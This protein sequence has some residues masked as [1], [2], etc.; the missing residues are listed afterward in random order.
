MKSNYVLSDNKLSIIINNRVCYSIDPDFYNVDSNLLGNIYLLHTLPNAKF[1]ETSLESMLYHTILDEQKKKLPIEEIRIF[2]TNHMEF[3]RSFKERKRIKK[4]LKLNNLARLRN[5]LEDLNNKLAKCP[6][7][8]IRVCKKIGAQKTKSI[9]YF[10]YL[11][12]EIIKNAN[13]ECL[14]IA[15]RFPA[16]YR[17]A[18]YI[19]SLRD[20]KFAQLAEVFPL[21]ACQ[22]LE[23][24]YRKQR[25]IKAIFNSDDDYLNNVIEKTDLSM[26]LKDLAEL[27]KLPMCLRNIKPYCVEYAYRYEAVKFAEKYPQ[28]FHAFMPTK[29]MQQHRWLSVLG[30]LRTHPFEVNSAD[31]YILWV[32]KNI[33]KKCNMKLNELNLYISEI[34]DWRRATRQNQDVIRLRVENLSFNSKLTLDGAIER[35]KQWHEQIHTIQREQRIINANKYV[36]PKP[37]FNDFEKDG[38]TISALTKG[39]DLVYEGDAMHHCVNTYAQ[40][41]ADGLCYI[42]SLKKDGERKATIELSI[43]HSNVFSYLQ[44]TMGIT[45]ITGQNTYANTYTSSATAPLMNTITKTYSIGQIRAHCNGDP[46]NEAKEIVNLWFNK[47]NK[48]NTK[49]NTQDLVMSLAV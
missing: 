34:D 49:T 1:R 44:G 3:S 35:S 45:A 40:R 25:R 43:S 39:E 17:L 8:Y 47:E 26:K 6:S 23:V 20:H 16:E 5:S 19:E 46:G 14:R 13:P 48:T 33:P 38:W 42:Y 22:I 32:M 21:L 30:I 27:Y 29:T 18:I 10:N 31:D 12:K 7:D 2:Q 9:K 11:V 36:F 15:R 24:R 37:P 4:E 41:V 28:A